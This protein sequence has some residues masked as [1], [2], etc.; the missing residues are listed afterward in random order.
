[1]QIK[2]RI[3]VV[4]GGAGGLELISLLGNKFGKNQTADITL[5]DRSPIHLWKPL[6]HEVAAGTLNTY[7]DEL[8]YHA[9]A[10]THYFKFC[11]GSLSKLD[12]AKKE[13]ILS[14]LID[15][16]GSEIL[17]ERSITYDILII[18]VG[19]I[20]NDFNIP[21][22]Q[23]NCMTI[24][25]SEQ[26]LKFQQYLIKTM[27]SLPYHTSAT[28]QFNIAVIGG[29]ATGVELTAELHYAL[30]Q[31]AIY[32]FEFDPKKITFN[33][34][35]AAD[36]L[37]PALTPRVSTAVQQRL[38]ELGVTLNLGEQVSQITKEGI[39][40][41]NGNFIPA[42]LAIWVAGIKAP[43]FLRSLDGLEV[44]K[45]NQLIVKSTLQT[46]LD[47]HIF[48]IGDCA[49]CIIES[50]GKP[51]PARAQ[52]AHQQAVFIIKAITQLL[53][54]KTLPTFHF[55]DYGSLISISSYQTVGNLMGRI[56][57]SLMI[58]GL[59]AR[60]A[61]LS[62]YRAHQAALYGPWQVG[63]LMFTNLLTRQIRPR[64]KLH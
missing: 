27:M 47:D 29:G 45:A 25:T 26:A 42:S 20:S 52:A 43:D 58:E 39:T 60:I 49:S 35:E 31:L 5:I 51:V 23:E 24:D 63:L 22:V 32:G 7:D 19:S 40:T 41:K 50:T 6:L 2:P 34:I 18:A 11:L 33:L 55:K 30:Q 8:S 59:L 44:N 64:L 46:T 21:G 38:Q 48:A 54:N 10:S 62:L 61:Y 4:G 57:K 36:R 37:L 13:L 28:G 1:M 16:D 17:P 14:P 56:L 53:Q 15:E 12:R 9:Y 3:V